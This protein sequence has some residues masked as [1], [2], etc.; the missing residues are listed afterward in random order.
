MKNIKQLG[1]NDCEAFHVFNND[2][3]IRFSET[4]NKKSCAFSDNCASQ[5]HPCKLHTFVNY[6][7]QGWEGASAKLQFLLIPHQL[8]YSMRTAFNIE[9]SQN[10][11]TLLMS[12]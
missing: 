6:T 7:I 8:A 5:I 10:R 1:V 2:V 9:N 4:K 12:P 3:L 11:T